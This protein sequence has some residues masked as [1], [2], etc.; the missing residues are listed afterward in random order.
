[1]QLIEA[2]LEFLDDMADDGHDQ[3]GPDSLEHAIETSAETVVVE[4]GQVL[5]VQS[6]EVRWDESGPVAH[7]IDG[8]AG[9]EEIGEEDHQRG[10]GGELGSGVI[11]G[12]MLLEEA[13]KLDALEDPS[14]QREGPDLVGAELKAVG[15]SELARGHV[16]VG[17]AWGG[18]GGVGEEI[19][20]GHG[21]SPQ[22]CWE[23]I[24]RPAS[25]RPGG[26]GGRQEARILK[27]LFY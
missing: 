15:L 6:Q 13:V 10:G 2:N 20:M 3:G 22:G 23:G 9:Q 12:E 14:D 11:L 5:G 24:D 19:G 16:A 1:M 4:S 17:A 8:L 25:K 18:G 26:A 27:I 7:A 21:K